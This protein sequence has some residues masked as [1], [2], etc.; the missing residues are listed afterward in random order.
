MSFAAQEVRSL[1]ENPYLF[2]SNPSRQH[3]IEALVQY[4]QYNQWDRA[5]LFFDLSEQSLLDVSL[6]KV[7][8]NHFWYVLCTIRFLE[9]F[10]L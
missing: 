6:K 5:A 7:F 8:V 9:L 1:S 4:F 2:K 10:L 3:F